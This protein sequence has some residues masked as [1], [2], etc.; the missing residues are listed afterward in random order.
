MCD[1]SDLRCY[2][3]PFFSVIICSHLL[4]TFMNNRFHNVICLAETLTGDLHS[5]IYFEKYMRINILIFV[6]SI[7]QS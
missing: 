3:P 5:L 4:L 7:K 2:V 6:S 1:N